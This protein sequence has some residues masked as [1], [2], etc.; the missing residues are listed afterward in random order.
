MQ[1]I[2]SLWGSR[3][4]PAILLVLLWGFASASLK[5]LK[6][7]YTRECYAKPI[8]GLHGN[9][10]VSTIAEKWQERYWTQG[11][12][13]C[14]YDIPLLWCNSRN[15]WRHTILLARSMRLCKTWITR[16][17]L[18]KWCSTSMFQRSPEAWS[19]HVL[20]LKRLSAFQVVWLASTSSI[21][22]WRIKL[23]TRCD[24]ENDW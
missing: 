3:D 9:M 10:E 23:K 13:W 7:L 12:G 22:W 18:K 21:R 4:L 1:A 17:L 16:S 11:D 5:R 14:Q 20:C 15:L 2:L 24:V 6:K 8:N 19:T